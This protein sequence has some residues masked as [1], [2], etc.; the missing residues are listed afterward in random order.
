MDYNFPP[1]NSRQQDKFKF[2]SQPSS[3][4]SMASSRKSNDT[5]EIHDSQTEDV[6]QDLKMKEDGFRKT[7]SDFGNS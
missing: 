6:N 5:I 2:N 7:I 1:V 3:P 4:N